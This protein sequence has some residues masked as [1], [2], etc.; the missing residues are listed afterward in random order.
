MIKELLS[1]IFRHSNLLN[2]LFGIKCCELKMHIVKS[3]NNN[4]ASDNWV[5][6]IKL[7]TLLVMLHIIRMFIFLNLDYN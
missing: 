6:V 2:I 3:R 7:L 1:K 4:F 5:Y